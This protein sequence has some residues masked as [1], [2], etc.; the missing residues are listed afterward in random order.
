MYFKSHYIL[1][2]QS[3]VLT[4]FVSSEKMTNNGSV[5]LKDLYISGFFYNRI[6]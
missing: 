2:L 4:N 3:E 6:I 5:F 1:F